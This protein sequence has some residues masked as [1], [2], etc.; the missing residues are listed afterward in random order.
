MSILFC[1]LLVSNL[2][3]ASPKDISGVLWPWRTFPVNSYAKCLSISGYLEV[4]NSNDVWYSCEIQ[5]I[6]KS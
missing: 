4:Q 5:I 6:D 3:L 2:I 1:L